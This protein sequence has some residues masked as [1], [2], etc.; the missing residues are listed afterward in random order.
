MSA[1]SRLP[2][3][4]QPGV[5]PA[6][7]LVIRAS[8]QP[9]PTWTAVAMGLFA[10][11]ALAELGATLASASRPAGAVAAFAAVAAL[12]VVA[13]WQIRRHAGVVRLE[14]R[15]DELRRVT[16]AG[17]RV[18]TA[19]GRVQRIVS[20]VYRSSGPPQRRW[21]LLTGDGR[22]VARLSPAYWAPEDLAALR[23]A[24]DVPLEERGRMVSGRALRRDIPG[25][26]PWAVAYVWVTVAAGLAA[27]IGLVVAGY[28]L[29]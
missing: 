3:S 13:L 25:S 9:V 6:P 10:L 29:L 1:G 24:L 8:A 26:V 12:T 5:E 4:T 18:L 28:Y 19:A 14:V 21:L 22:A 17:T 23:R 2:V 16:P 20:V 27:V 7:Q 15:G 11:A